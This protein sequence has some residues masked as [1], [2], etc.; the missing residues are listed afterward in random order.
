MN[1]DET[2][3]EWRR[4]SFAWGKTDCL[5]SVADY[6]SDHALIGEKARLI[7]AEY[8][9]QYSNEADGLER[10]TRDGGPEAII[11]RSGLPRTDNPR[12]GDVVVIDV[13]AGI[14]GV[15]TGHSVVIRRER[16]VAEINLKLIK[17]KSAWSID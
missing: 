12:R 5:L 10:M 11:D 6:L 8:R 9:N 1:I 14:A 3:K 13:A 16:G 4:S 15:H 7:A 17:I 2:L